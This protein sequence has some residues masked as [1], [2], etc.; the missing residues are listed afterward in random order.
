MDDYA[1]T[2]R[3]MRQ[4]IGL[5]QAAL[6]KRTGIPRTVINAYEHGRREPKCEVL[7]LIADACGWQIIAQPKRKIDAARNDRVLQEVLDLAELL[8]SR[9]SKDLK[10]PSLAKQ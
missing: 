1:T 3:D 10:F 5:S 7:S 2:I 4:S 6:A 8:P 9:P